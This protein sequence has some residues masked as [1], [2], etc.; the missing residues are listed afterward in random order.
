MKYFICT[1]FFVFSDFQS[2]NIR[3]FEP[4]PENQN[5]IRYELQQIGF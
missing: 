1:M 3:V 5:T 2:I 4:I